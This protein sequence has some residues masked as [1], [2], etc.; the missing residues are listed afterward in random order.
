[1]TQISTYELDD[2]IIL[3]TVTFPA[4]SEITSLTG[5]T[6]EAVARNDQTG[7]VISANSCSITSSTTIRAAFAENVFTQGLWRIQIRATVSGVTQTLADIRL[8]AVD[9][10]TV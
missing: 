8:T 10:L 5:G 1:M 9:S 3:L 4:G 6:A 2:T 7:T